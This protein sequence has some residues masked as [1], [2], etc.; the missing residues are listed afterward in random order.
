MKIRLNSDNSKVVGNKV[1]ITKTKAFSLNDKL[2]KNVNWV[3]R[4]KH[5]TLGV[6]VEYNGIYSRK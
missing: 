2:K 4:V 1:Y 5:P 6:L 3:D